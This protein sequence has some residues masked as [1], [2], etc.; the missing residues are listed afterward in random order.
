MYKVSVKS[1]L[2]AHR[3]FFIL[4]WT[5]TL[6]HDLKNIQSYT[7]VLPSKYCWYHTCHLLIGNKKNKTQYGRTLGLRCSWLYTSLCIRF[8]ISSYGLQYRHDFLAYTDAIMESASAGRRQFNQRVWQAINRWLS[9][10]VKRY[11]NHSTW[12][13]EAWN[14]HMVLSDDTPNNPEITA[15]SMKAREGI[16]ET[17]LYRKRESFSW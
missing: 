10:L 6:I 15:M 5:R 13:M 17:R 9:P 7:A 11:A 16:T 14:S 4:L 2:H 1:I 3:L 8:C 12:N